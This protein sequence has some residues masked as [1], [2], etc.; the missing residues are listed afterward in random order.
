MGV[1]K[2][3]VCGS[4]LDPRLAAAARAERGRVS[5]HSPPTEVAAWRAPPRSASSLAARGAESHR[6]A[7]DQGARFMAGLRVL[8]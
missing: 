7:D 6:D 1:G 2:S 3:S 4:V 5:D 8:G